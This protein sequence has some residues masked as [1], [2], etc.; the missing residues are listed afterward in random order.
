MC[1]LLH[2]M[3]THFIGN[4]DILCLE[5]KKKRKRAPTDDHC[6]RVYETGEPAPR[7]L[8]RK[9][10]ER[11]RGDEHRGGEESCWTP[12]TASVRGEVFL[13]CIDIV[14]Y[15]YS[16]YWK[17]KGSSGVPCARLRFLFFCFP[18]RLRFRIPTQKKIV[19]SFSAGEE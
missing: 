14:P 15:D 5:Y 1:F 18:L 7:Q 11:R 4:T 8:E 19:L 12:P 3:S 10:G 2:V 9:G 6:W 17:N 16:M 13:N